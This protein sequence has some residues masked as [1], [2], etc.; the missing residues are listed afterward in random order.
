MKKTDFAKIKGMVG[1]DCVMS[2][3]SLNTKEVGLYIAL[4]G[5]EDYF[6]EETIKRSL[7]TY[8]ESID[9]PGTVEDFRLFLELR[10]EAREALRLQIRLAS[11]KQ[12][13]KDILERMNKL[14]V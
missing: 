5:Q 7:N 1:E 3:V 9:L 11:I 8:M 2:T 14:G 4:R 12:E 6:K 13:E 10:E